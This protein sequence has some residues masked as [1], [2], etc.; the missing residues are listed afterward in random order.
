MKFLSEITTSRDILV[1]RSYVTIY[2]AVYTELIYL[3]HLLVVHLAQIT[4]TQ[5]TQGRKYE[6]QEMKELGREYSWPYFN[7]YSGICLNW[8]KKTRKTFRKFFSLPLRWTCSVCRIHIFIKLFNNIHAM[9]NVSHKY[10]TLLGGINPTVWHQGF[11][12]NSLLK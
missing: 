11:I 5:D 9:Y 12:L 2:I 10:F 6:W 8:L 7:Y 1:V 3:F 4:M